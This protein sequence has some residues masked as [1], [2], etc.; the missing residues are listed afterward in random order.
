M[1]NSLFSF[2]NPP[3]DV[4]GTMISINS[5]GDNRKGSSRVMVKLFYP[6]TANTVKRDF[7]LLQR[8]GE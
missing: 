6:K 8:Q 3:N 2:F 1:S 7:S 5:I 4:L